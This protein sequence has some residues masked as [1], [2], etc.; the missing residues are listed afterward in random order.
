MKG[1][2]KGA[3]SY[4][5]ETPRAQ[6]KVPGEPPPGSLLTPELLSSRGTINQVAQCSQGHTVGNDSEFSSHNLTG[7]RGQ[8]SI[9]SWLCL[10]S[11]DQ[12]INLMVGRKQISASP[13]LW[14]YCSSNTFE[15][16]QWRSSLL[17]SSNNRKQQVSSVRRQLASGHPSV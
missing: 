15:L 8:L 3:F 7:S 12:S 10:D 1:G 17:A 11:A 9:L 4:L 13:N 5:V 14:M 6:V 16:I 2:N